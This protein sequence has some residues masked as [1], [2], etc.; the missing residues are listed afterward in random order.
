M[1]VRDYLLVRLNCDEISA[2]LVENRGG[3]TKI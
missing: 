3:P 1:V 2:G